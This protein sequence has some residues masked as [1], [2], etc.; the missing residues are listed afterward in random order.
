MPVQFLTPNQR[1]NFGRYVGDP[2]GDD[3]TRYFHLDEAD[4]AVIGEKRG[5][6]NRL[7]FALQLTTARFLGTFLEDPLDVPGIVLQKLARQ[8]RITDL[9][10][11]SRYRSADQRWEH[12]AEIRSRYDFRSWDDPVVGFRLS[13]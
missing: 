8:L 13:R 6:H 10:Q 1:A 9:E 3:L 7:G 12:T 2:S 4:H 5:D 11:L